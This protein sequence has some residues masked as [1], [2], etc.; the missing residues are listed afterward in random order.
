MW[1]I[2]YLCNKLC[3]SAQK[4]KYPIKYKTRCPSLG[5]GFYVELVMGLEPATC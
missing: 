2:S 4:T 1:A 3:N 5:A